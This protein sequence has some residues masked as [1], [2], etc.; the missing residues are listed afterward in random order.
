MSVKPKNKTKS[1][2]LET[3]VIKYGSK[4]GWMRSDTMQQKREKVKQ[5]GPVTES[6]T[7]DTIKHEL[8][9]K[10]NWSNEWNSKKEMHRY[11]KWI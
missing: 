3:V 2:N 8:A 10:H 5:S 11:Y 1:K 4:K 6:V 7:E 9:H